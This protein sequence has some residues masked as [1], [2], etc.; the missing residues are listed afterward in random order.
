MADTHALEQQFIDALHAL[1]QGG[2]DQLDALVALFRDD[3]EV[4]NAALKL[5]GKT[6]QGSDD[7]RTFWK[8][9]RHTF[10]TMRSEFAH[11][12]TSD[13]A[14][15]LFWRTSGT[16]KDGNDM[17][18]DGVSL[19][20]FDGNGKIRHFRGYYDTRDLTRSVEQA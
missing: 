12:T 3:A 19:L 8:E 13:D 9:Y 18:Y 15:G 11:V 10:A 6:R 7:V 5:A 1:E 20:V 16:G 4:T 2:E 14:A 17:S